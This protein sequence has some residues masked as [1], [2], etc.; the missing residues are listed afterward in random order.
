[1]LKPTSRA[2]TF[3]TESQLLDNN[4]NVAS[5]QTPLLLLQK[6]KDDRS[7]STNKKVD[8]RPLK[9]GASDNVGER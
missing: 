2:S 8:N 1:M 6:D 4:K 7:F 5:L 9:P 3:S